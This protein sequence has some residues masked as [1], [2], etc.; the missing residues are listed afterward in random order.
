LARALPRA[1]VIDFMGSP[2]APRESW[3]TWLTSGKLKCPFAVKLIAYLLLCH[4]FSENGVWMRLH[5]FNTLC[6][7]PALP[8][9]QSGVK[10]M[11]AGFAKMGT[12]T[13]SRTLFELGYER[14][15]H[16]EEYLNHVWHPIY[17]DYWAKPENGGHV[18]PKIGSMASFWSTEDMEVLNNT[19]PELI[20]S[21]TSRCR[22]D[23]V[24]LDGAEKLFWPIMEVSPTAKVLVLNWRTYAKAKESMEQF[25]MYFGPWLIMMGNLDL[26]IHVFPWALIF[27]ALEPLCGSPMH[28]LLEEGGPPLNQVQS[29]YMMLWQ[30]HMANVR[31]VGHWMM[32]L[33]EWADASEESHEAFF[34]RIKRDVPPERRMEV[35]PRKTTYEDLCRFLELEPCKKSGRI[36][37]AINLG[38][39]E[40]DFLPAFAM[41][42]P[43]Y[44]LVHWCN[45][46]LLHWLLWK[47]RL[48]LLAAYRH[49]QLK[50]GKS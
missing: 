18:V 20:A 26:C 32:G 46:K 34:E 22:T 24:A 50:R 7:Y 41:L 19:A 44:L 40:L 38:N 39:H 15:Y 6:R 30:R 14:S 27:L 37:R 49:V 42:T 1:A 47:L 10:V 9:N 12:R 31:Y 29:P 36:P 48:G 5:Q 11:I 8:T 4:N 13:M 16:G 23:A 33:S 25:V 3:S 21:G 2:S 35:D 43:V 17:Y 45:W 28:K